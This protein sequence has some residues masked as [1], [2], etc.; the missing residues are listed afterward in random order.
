[1]ATPK[2]KTAAELLKEKLG[3]Y[4]EQKQEQRQA[5]INHE[6]Q[7]Y[8]YRLA[9]RLDDLKHKA[10]YIRYAKSVPR[11][12]LEDAAAFTATYTSAKNKGKVFSWKLR[13]LLSEYKE[14][15]P[16]FKMGP[17]ARKVKSDQAKKKAESKTKGKNESKPKPKKAKSEPDNLSLF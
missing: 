2:L 12:L 13:E 10:M 16:E 9:Y 3:Q 15:H 1:M 17:T 5:Y 11:A 7:D 14:K 6:F 8:G 4:T